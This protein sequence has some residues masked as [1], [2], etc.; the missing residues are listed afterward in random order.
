M[1]ASH[2]DQYPPNALMVS[3]YIEQGLLFTNIKYCIFQIT[4][5]GTKWGL[6]EF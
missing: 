6:Y 5:L 2:T 1:E 3:K 4:H